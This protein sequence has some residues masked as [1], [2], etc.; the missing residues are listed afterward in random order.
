MPPHGHLLRI[1]IEGDNPARVAEVAEALAE[2]LAMA[3][4]EMTVRGPSRLHRLRGRTRRAILLQAPLSSTLTTATRRVLAA[5]GVPGGVR[6]G[7][8]VDPQDT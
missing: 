8:D 4:P 6:I 2:D 7:I 5:S 3:D 1:V